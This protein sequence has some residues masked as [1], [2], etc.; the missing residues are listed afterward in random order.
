MC[1]GAPS[2]PNT[3]TT[4]QNLQPITPANDPKIADWSPQQIQEFLVKYPTALRAASAGSQQQLLDG[5]SASSIWSQVAGTQVGRD[6]LTQH[7]ANRAAAG[8]TTEADQIR[9]YLSNTD[10]TKLTRLPTLAPPPPSAAASSVAPSDIPLLNETIAI[11]RAGNADLRI[12][13]M[14][15]MPANGLPTINP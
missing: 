1:I 5:Y 8:D 11:N 13:L 4:L 3:V 9:S 2:Q 12:P 6:F 14:R 10:P 7:A 15:P